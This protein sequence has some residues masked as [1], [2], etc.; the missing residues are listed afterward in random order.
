MRLATQPT[1]QHQQNREHP[2]PDSY[3]PAVPLWLPEG[4]GEERRVSSRIRRFH[5]VSLL[6]FGVLFP[7]PVGSENAERSCHAVSFRSDPPSSG[8]FPPP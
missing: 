2:C 3:G 8:E 5:V 1:S 7:V 6:A 4:R